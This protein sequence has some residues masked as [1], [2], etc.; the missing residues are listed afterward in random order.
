MYDVSYCNF[1]NKYNINIFIATTLAQY[2]VTVVIDHLIPLI[3]GS[4]RK[5]EIVKNSRHIIL[6][7]ALIIRECIFKSKWGLGRR[8]NVD[9]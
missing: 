2:V 9:E 4:R 3:N 6:K 5:G 1:F 8:V 7:H